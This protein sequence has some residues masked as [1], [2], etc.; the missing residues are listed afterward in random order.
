MSK[1]EK[2]S[3]GFAE[4][5]WDELEEWAGSKIVGRGRNYQKDGRVSGLVKILNR[6]FSDMIKLLIN[7]LDGVV[8]MR[9]R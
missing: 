3:E 7:V 4:L 8:L 6:Y 5:T 2:S 1:R 9:M